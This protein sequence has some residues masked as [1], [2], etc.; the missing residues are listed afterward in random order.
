VTDKTCAIL[1]ET[2][3]G[4]GGI[5]PIDAIY[6]QR[7]RELCDKKGILL[8]L[9]EIQCGMGR[10]GKLLAYE[11][12]N[13][14]PDIVTLAKALGCGVPVGAFAAKEHVASAFE[15]G[16]HGTT[17]GGNPFAAAAVNAVFEQYEQKNLVE[18]IREIG[19]YLYRALERVKKET[20]GVI[21]HRGMGL[22]Q[23]LEFDAPVRPIIEKAMDSGVIFINA[24]ANVLRF[25]PPLVIEQQHVDEMVSV[26]V[27]SIQQSY[28]N[29]D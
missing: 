10:T 8:I 11:H 6:L 20:T 15:S 29:G 14:V 17:Y 27:E 1:L 12:Y 5:H 21:A 23:G 16:D 26:L 19:G 3:Q 9:D 18:H 4:E 25:L 28:K 2:L 13:I 7:V 22:M 24:G